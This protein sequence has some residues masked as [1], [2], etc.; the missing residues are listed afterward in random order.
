MQPL[1]RKANHSASPRVRVN[2]VYRS[3]SMSPTHLHATA[4]IKGHLF[5][6]HNGVQETA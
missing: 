1:E 4:L 2:N 5:L 6:R 3:N